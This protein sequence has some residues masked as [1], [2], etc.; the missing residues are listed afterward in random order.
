MKR[1]TTRDMSRESMET[2][3]R[4]RRIDNFLPKCAMLES[5]GLIAALMNEK[6]DIARTRSES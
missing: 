4:H 1:D 5:R 2:N 3:P 6:I